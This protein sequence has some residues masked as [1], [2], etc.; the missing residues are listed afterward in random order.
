M[1]AT[2]GGV[3]EIVDA[4]IIKQINE[5]SLILKKPKAINFLFVFP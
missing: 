1:T 5:I 2:I 3:S 4:H